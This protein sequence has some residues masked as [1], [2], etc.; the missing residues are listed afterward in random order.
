MQRITLR[1]KLVAASLLVA[2][3]PLASAAP[4]YALFGGSVDEACQGVN[5]G[6]GSSCGTTGTTQI[7]KLIT[8]IVNI[9]SQIVGIAAVIV[10]IVAGFKFITASGDPSKVASAKNTAIYAIVGLLVAVF[11][12]ALVKLVLAKATR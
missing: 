7:N 3:V 5:T 6:S 12:Q 4:A 2:A 10:M 9:L 11:S 1:I 8:T